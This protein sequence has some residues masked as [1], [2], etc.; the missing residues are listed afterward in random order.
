MV[1]VTIYT[2]N[3]CGFCTAAKSL[4]SEKGAAFTEHNASIEPS[5]RQEMLARSN[6]RTTFPQVFIGRTHVG[7]C[8][9]LYALENQGR[10]DGLLKTGEL[11]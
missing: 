8:D 11:A 6:G 7:G 3:G 1:D 2:R 9:D 10:L 4:L 5:A